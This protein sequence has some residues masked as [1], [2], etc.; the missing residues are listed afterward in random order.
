MPSE[1]SFACSSKVPKNSVFNIRQHDEIF[2]AEGIA[3]LEC[4][5][6]VEIAARVP[7]RGWSQREESVAGRGGAAVSST[8]EAVLESGHQSIG[9]TEGHHD[10]GD[11]GKDRAHQP[12][13]ALALGELDQGQ[14]EH[15]RGPDRDADHDKETDGLANGVTG[16]TG[17]LG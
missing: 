4:G 9:K 12:A 13:A 10:R 6:F 15:D 11:A 16:I 8:N 5:I 1:V 2:F 14:D 17:V 7:M 3:E